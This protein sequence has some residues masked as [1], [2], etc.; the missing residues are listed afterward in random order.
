MY[1]HGLESN[2]MMNAL[3]RTQENDQVNRGLAHN[4]LIAGHQPGPY[5]SFVPGA[6]PT[7]EMSH[8]FNLAFGPTGS[9]Q[10]G[11]LLATAPR[12]EGIGGGFRQ[13]PD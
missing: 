5:Q 9:Q 4:A 10:S 7:P 3:L 8:Q 1:A 13:S 11:G 12:P 6:H 2:A